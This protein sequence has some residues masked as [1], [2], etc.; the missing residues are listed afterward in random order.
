MKRTMT[1]IVLLLT[2]GPAI[3][4]GP[5]HGTWD[6]TYGRLTL[7]QEGDKVTGYY[8][9]E[10]PCWID[11]KV[12]GGKLKFDYEEPDAKGSG[13]FEIAKDGKSFDG[14]WGVAGQEQT[15]AWTGTRMSDKVPQKVNT[16]AGTYQTTFGKMVLKQDGAKVTG[17]YLMGDMKCDIEGK[18]DGLV[19]KFRYDE[20][21][22][23]GEGQ[24]RR[25]DDGMVFFGKWRQDGTT[26]FQPWKGEKAQD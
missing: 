7:R 25:S 19:L 5:F 17:H 13:T 24:F 15:E 26:E 14:K 8:I 4:E 3:A 9:M 10:V 22:T 12:V 11:G 21:G 6:T 16:Y 23:K 2:V 1:G 18:V 20:N